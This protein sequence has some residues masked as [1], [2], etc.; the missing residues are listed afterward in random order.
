MATKIKEVIGSKIYTAENGQKITF[1]GIYETT[2]YEL[3]ELVKGNRPKKSK[4]IDKMAF[5]VVKIGVIRDVIVFHFNHKYYTGDGQHLSE[6]LKRF[7]GTVPIRYKLI[8]VNTEIEMFEMVA[9]INGS[10]VRLSLEEYIKGWAEYNPEYNKLLNF[11]K[12]YGITYRVL[13]TILTGLKSKAVEAIQSG[14]FKV[15]DIKSAKNKIQLI[16]EFKS[17]VGKKLDAYGVDGLVK[18][19][20]VIGLDTY[21]K[22][23]FIFM[24][25]VKELLN[26]YGIMDKNLGRTDD[27]IN[28][29]NEVYSKIK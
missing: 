27:Y 22:E 28:F 11:K 4:H 6:V 1:H 17:Y 12:E 20:D 7:G 19:I 9:L 26:L 23:K 29:F 8:N 10:Q 2:C 14:N 5:S 25:K 13:A 24:D 3:F 21:N 15:V 16:Y 18:F